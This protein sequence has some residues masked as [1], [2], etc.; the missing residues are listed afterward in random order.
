M[1]GVS[2]SYSS[3]RPLV[4][5][6]VSSILNNKN[7]WKRGGSWAVERRSLKPVFC[8]PCVSE[9][10]MFGRLYGGKC[11]ITMNALRCKIS[12]TRL[13]IPSLKSLPPTDDSLALYLKL[14]HIQAMLWK[15]GDRNKPPNKR[16]IV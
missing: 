10:R 7:N 14:V 15:A 11:D 8:N 5:L 9:C 1:F 13:Q 3:S 16:V 2:L 4:V 6:R 12:S